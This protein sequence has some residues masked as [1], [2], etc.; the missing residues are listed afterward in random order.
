MK[1]IFKWFSIEMHIMLYLI[2]I[3]PIKVSEIGYFYHYKLFLPEL[4]DWN[5]IRNIL[6]L[7]HGRICITVYGTVYIQE[8]R[9]WT[10]V[11][12]G[13]KRSWKSLQKPNTKVHL[14]RK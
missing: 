12:V 1:S 9:V 10:V 6:L 5:Q 4:T 13:N 11:L 7:Q 14:G 8:P 3:K 2:L